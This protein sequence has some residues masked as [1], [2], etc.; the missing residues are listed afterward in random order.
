MKMVTESVMKKGTVSI[1]GGLCGDS[2]KG[3]RLCDEWFLCAWLNVRFVVLF[4]EL[5]GSY[6]NNHPRGKIV[7]NPIYDRH[8]GVSGQR[9]LTVSK[10]IKIHP[11]ADDE[12]REAKAQ[13]RQ[14]G[15]RC[16]NR[17]LISLLDIFCRHVKRF[18]VLDVGEFHSAVSGNICSAAMQSFGGHP[19]TV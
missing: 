12:L 3:G 8:G 10:I 19:L 11:E 2:V 7:P 6:T 15:P 13:G 5:S 16:R 4:E 1:S 14:G 18:A 9:R 17:K